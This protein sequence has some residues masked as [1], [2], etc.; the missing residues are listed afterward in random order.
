MGKINPK[1]EYHYT[2]G[3]GWSQ[4]TFYMKDTFPLKEA[5]FEGVLFPVPNNADAYLTKVYGDWRKIPS[6]E[7]IKQS[8]HCKEYREEIYGKDD[9]NI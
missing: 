9:K 1:G 4:H 2:L 8:I 6:P 7:Q 5:S 3:T